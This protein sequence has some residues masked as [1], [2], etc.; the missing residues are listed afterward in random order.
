MLGYFKDVKLGTTGCNFAHTLSL[1]VALLLI[2]LIGVAPRSVPCALI[3]LSH[4][5]F[6]R[7]LGFGLK[8]PTAF[9]DTHFQRV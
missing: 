2:G 7:M 4:I 1:P 5:E 9:R 6:D 8:Y 3:W